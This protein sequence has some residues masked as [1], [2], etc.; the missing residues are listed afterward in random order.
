MTNNTCEVSFTVCLQILDL[1]RLARFVLPLQLFY[2]SL[3]LEQTNVAHL[4]LLEHVG[5]K[6]DARIYFMH[7]GL[8]NLPCCEW[9][10]HGKHT[11][12]EKSNENSKENRQFLAKWQ[13]LLSREHLAKNRDTKPKQQGVCLVDARHQFFVR[14]NLTRARPGIVML[15]LSLLLP[16]VS[17]LPGTPAWEAH[18]YEFVAELPPHD[19]L[20]L[21]IKELRA[22]CSNVQATPQVVLYSAAARFNPSLEARAVSIC[23]KVLDEYVHVIHLDNMFSK[24]WSSAHVYCKDVS[25]P[26]LFVNRFGSM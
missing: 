15:T 25:P 10:Q 2:D 7:G 17:L 12:H 6:F 9:H 5:A 26:E 19:V 22:V 18:V 20:T 23:K 13:Q 4:S 14:E 1:S 8:L 3:H 16:G 11:F 21:L 24:S